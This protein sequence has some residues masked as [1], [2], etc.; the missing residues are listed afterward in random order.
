MTEII[1]VIILIK[2]RTSKIIF[3]PLIHSKI[4]LKYS[5]GQYYKIFAHFTNHIF[6]LFSLVDI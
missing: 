1:A 6:K 3:N 2:L 4:F 5:K